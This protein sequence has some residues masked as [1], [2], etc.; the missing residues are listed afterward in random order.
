MSKSTNA[1][2]GSQAPDFT[3]PDGEGN[4]WRLSDQQG[5]VVVLLF[6]P[7][8]ETPICT[9]QMCSVRDNWEDYVATGAEVVGLSTNTVASHKDFAEHHNLPLRLLADVDRKVADAYGAKSLVPGKVA[10][11]VFVIDGSGA[12][13]YRDV[14][15]LGL[16]RPKDEEIIEAIR[17]AQG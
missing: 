3:L 7:G 15:P 5:K 6:Y 16:F 4:Q 14:R 1:G 12:I 11:S 13:R 8:D 9:R 17:A 10:R 2:V